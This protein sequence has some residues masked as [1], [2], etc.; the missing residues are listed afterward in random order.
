M[1]IRPLPEGT[2]AIVPYLIMDN[3]AKAMDFYKKVFAAEEMMRM[4][5][6]DGKKIMHAEMR[7]AGCMVW[8]SDECADM[9][10]QSPKTA[11]TSTVGITMYC[12]D[13]DKVFNRAVKAGAKAVKPMENQFWG[14]RMGTLRDPFGH[15]W[16]LMQ[17][18]EEVP[19][20]EMMERS[21][22]AMA[23]A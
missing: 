13:A 22:K 7:I 23:H 12:L 1:P 21:K 6:P 19:P 15:L 5:S 9:G 18:V 3:A 2:H 8:M 14:D 4:P 10:F 11:G 17:R 16:T 20:A